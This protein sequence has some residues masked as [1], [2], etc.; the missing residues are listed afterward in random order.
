M[1]DLYSD[2]LGGTNGMSAAIESLSEFCLLVPNRGGSENILLSSYSLPLTSIA[3]AERYKRVFLRDE[4]VAFRDKLINIENPVDRKAYLSSRRKWIED[5]NIVSLTS[6]KH[7]NASADGA[8]AFSKL[9]GVG[10]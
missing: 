10:T 8:L 3:S 4:L 6:Y 1:R 5:L 7:G 9:R 2:I